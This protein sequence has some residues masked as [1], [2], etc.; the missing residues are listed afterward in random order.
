V[1][2]DHEPDARAVDV[3]NVPEIQHEL[4]TSAADQII[5]HFPA[6]RVH[7]AHIELPADR[8]DGDVADEPLRDFHGALRPRPDARTTE[9]V[10][11]RGQDWIAGKDHM[12]HTLICR[13][14]YG[15]REAVVTTVFGADKWAPT[16]S[17]SEAR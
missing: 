3:R 2:A 15:A 17:S 9:A 5:D 4:S 13:P 11:R 10:D 14:V 6:A 7:R 1:S 8:D 12:D 16:R